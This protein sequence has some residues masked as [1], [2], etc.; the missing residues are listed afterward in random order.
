MKVVAFMH[1]AGMQLFLQYFFRKLPRRH[2]RKI[3]SEGQKQHRVQAAGLEQAKFF[4]S[5]RDQLQP[6]IRPQN[7]DRD[8]A[9]R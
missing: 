6:G 3:A 7:A 4:R 8:G 1:F 9:R 2:Q 5:G